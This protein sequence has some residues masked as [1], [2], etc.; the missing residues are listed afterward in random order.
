MNEGSLSISQ[1][2]LVGEVDLPRG[3][4]LQGWEVIPGNLLGKEKNTLHLEAQGNQA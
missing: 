4:T 1:E 2:P 3:G